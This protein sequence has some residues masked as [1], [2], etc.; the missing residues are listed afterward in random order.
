MLQKHALQVL[1]PE[2][3]R[4]RRRQTSL[5][6]G[7]AKRP[8]KWV[9]T[10]LLLVINIGCQPAQQASPTATFAGSYPIKVTVTVGMIGD[11]VRE[12][13][14]E[15]VR[16]T[17]LMAA[18]VDPHLYKPL[19]DAVISIRDA[20]LVFYNGLM[21]EGKMSELLAQHS[22]V[23]RT[24][25]VGE[26]LPKDSVASNDAS[27]HA[28]PDP[29]VWMNVELWR[30]AAGAIGNELAAF[31]PLHA[32]D[33]SDS[34]AR[35]QAKLL[36]LHEYGIQVMS[37][38]P[39]QQR[40]LVTSHDTFRYFG[41]AYGVEVQAIQGI[42]TESEAGLSRINE[43]VDILA[44]RK[45]RAIFTESSVP[46]DSIRALLRGAESKGHQVRIPEESLYSDAMGEA[47]TYEGT[48]IG[49]MDHNLSLIARSLG[50]QAVPEH[51]F[52]GASE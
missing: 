43:L 19:R 27:E 50:C 37:C 4:I 20:D 52:R 30:Q 49:M 47:G 35:L 46:K 24:F 34:A 29:H 33:Y 17:Q 23:K 3:L 11:L 44:S 45:I 48:Y 5:C 22:R 41:Q 39:E 26:S 31:D 14:G 25:A 42:S 32:N 8:S 6:S 13:G 12:I 7:N 40:V 28:H 1:A 18:G 16:V 9:L 51:G 36:G 10:L 15:H 38:I 2:F 21:L